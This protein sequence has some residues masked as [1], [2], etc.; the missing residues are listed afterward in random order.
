MTTPERPEPVGVYWAFSLWTIM[1]GVVLALAP[2][3]WFGPSWH[4]F[5]QFPQDGFWMGLCCMMLGTW[6]ML[7]LWRSRQGG[8]LS[9]RML[10]ALF[11]C[12]GFVF[13]TSGL[14]LGVAGLIGH[15]GLMEAPFM[16]Y[17]GAHQ[18]AYSAELLAR[19]RQRQ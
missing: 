1:L 16:L 8:R 11:F 7:T 3:N 12:S 9:G 15:Q 14:T 2:P 13:W 17:V 5:K 6:Q 10:G 19:S 4:F 18:F